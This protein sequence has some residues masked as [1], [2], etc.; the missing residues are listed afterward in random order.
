M[1]NNDKKP[2]AAPSVE[3]KPKKSLRQ[4]LEEA[5]IEVLPSEHPT[6]EVFTEE[7]LR[8][9]GFKVPPRRGEVT[10]ESLEAMTLADLLPRLPTEAQSWIADLDAAD[11]ATTERILNDI[12]AE[13]FL[14]YW[15]IHRDA[16]QD[17]Y[18]PL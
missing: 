6:R 3:N 1:S 14:R 4:R 10:R 8:A 16:Q 11:Y 9:L 13:N 17:A 12:G 7:S 18:F 5:G 2:D 15:R